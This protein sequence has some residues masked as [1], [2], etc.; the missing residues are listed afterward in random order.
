MKM[1]E[2]FEASK[3]KDISELID[4]TAESHRPILITAENNNAV[5]MSEEDFN[6]MQETLHLVSVPGMRDSIVEGLNGTTGDF[7]SEDE[8]R[9]KI[10]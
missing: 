2:T 6:S 9:S 1:L 3:V 8:F 10:K 4:D 5:L 7:L